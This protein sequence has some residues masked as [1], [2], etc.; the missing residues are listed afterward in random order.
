M[1]TFNVMLVILTDLDHLLIS[2]GVDFTV[3]IYQMEGNPIGRLAQLT[4]CSTDWC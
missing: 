2:L 3:I 4:L 1:V